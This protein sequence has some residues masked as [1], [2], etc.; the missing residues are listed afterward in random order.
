M[1]KARARRA[2]ER[3]DWSGTR[4]ARLSTE[5]IARIL[6][7]EPLTEEERTAHIDAMSTPEER[8]LRRRI[9]EL[10]DE[11]PAPAEA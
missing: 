3:T 5:D 9:R 4:M 11:R 6:S 1:T 2:A 8:E 7:D 10:I